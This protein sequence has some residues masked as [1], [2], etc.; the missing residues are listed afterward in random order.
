MQETQIRSL[1]QE[2]PL[3]EMATH[4]SIL[5]WRILWTEEPGSYSPWGCRVDTTE[6]LSMHVGS[7]MRKKP[8]AIPLLLSPLPLLTRTGAA[9]TSPVFITARVFPG[10]F[11]ATS[12]S[13]S[14]CS[15]RMSASFARQCKGAR[16]LMPPSGDYVNT[17]SRSDI[18]KTAHFNWLP[19]PSPSPGSYCI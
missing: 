4:C 14:I 8:H 7:L 5:A 1:D 12:G 11:L 16:M 10:G 17:L 15:F 6:R 19:L 18:F 2:D 9:V 13:N 3:E